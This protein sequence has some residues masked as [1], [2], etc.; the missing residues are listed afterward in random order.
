MNKIIK[1][2]GFSF[3]FIITF[4]FAF[5]FTK[6]SIFAEPLLV[7]KNNFPDPVLR[8]AVL[9]TYTY[10]CDDAGNFVTDEKGNYYVESDYITSIYCYGKMGVKNLKGIELLNNLEA[11]H[12][13]NSRFTVADF[14]NNA[15]LKIVEITGTSVKD[16]KL[17]N[18]DTLTTLSI[19]APAFESD[20]SKYPNL[21]RLSIVSDKLTSLDVS[22]FTKLK[23]F[24]LKA[25]NIKKL[26]FS[27]NTKLFSITLTDCN[28][29]R[30]VSFDETLPLES[31]C[32]KN[33]PKLTTIDI[34]KSLKLNYLDI[35]NCGITGI[36]VSKNKELT[37]L[38]LPFNRK[39]SSI[40]I[41][42]NK[43]LIELNIGST[44][45][46]R[47]NTSRNVK[48]ENLYVYNT[49]IKSL[50]LKN[51]KALI[52]I[53]FNGSR[54]KSLPLNKLYKDITITYYDVRPG[55][56]FSLSGFIGKGY[57]A[58]TAS[59]K[60]ISYNSQT[61]GIKTARPK[62][63]QDYDSITLKKGKLTYKINIFY[64]T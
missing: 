3:T 7:D 45:I 64:T 44:A 59:N 26:D 22:A 38:R 23:R 35:T 43:E 10:I 5:L 17:Y 57:K 6:Q 58:S 29:L 46:S 28:N 14:S 56:A 48:L 21:S 19:N 1:H 51:N 25:K 60:S 32:I 42:K 50:N 9:D 37:S 11:V 54:I 41:S 27:G 34:S 18:N 33:S 30:S 31:V 53:C 40:D 55:T 20:I 13:R 4:S 63:K 36:D 61:G 15:K 52:D 12:L 24:T 49:Q 2:L 62:N 8:Q 39:L 16:M 47:L